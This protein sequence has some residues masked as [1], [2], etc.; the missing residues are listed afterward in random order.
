MCVCFFLVI[1]RTRVSL[2]LRLRVGYSELQFKIRSNFGQ[3]VH[4]K[5][6]DLVDFSALVYKFGVSKQHRAKLADTTSA[7]I[8]A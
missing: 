8:F 1:S 5:A 6:K 7:E 3:E 2:H 4:N